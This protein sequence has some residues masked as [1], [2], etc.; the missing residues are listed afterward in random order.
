MLPKDLVGELMHF[1][2]ERSWAQFHTPRNLAI[3]LSLRAKGAV[4][5]YTELQAEGDA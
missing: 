2:A 5:K 4:K 1:R 3:S